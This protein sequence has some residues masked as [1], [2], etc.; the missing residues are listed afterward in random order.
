MRTLTKTIDVDV[1]VD[2]GDFTFQELL[3]EL[4]DRRQDGNRLSETGEIIVMLKTL[5]CPR[6]IIEDLK[7]WD[8]APIPDRRKLLEWESACK[9]TSL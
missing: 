2:L 3:D 9:S 1:D 5:G 7:D 6:Q 8:S 4:A